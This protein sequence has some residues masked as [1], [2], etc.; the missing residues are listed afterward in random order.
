MIEFY[1][2]TTPNGFKVA[3]CLEEMNLPYNINEVDILQGV[4]KQDWFLKL[5]PNGKIPVIVDTENDDFPVFESG[6]ILL[7]L[8]EKTGEFLPKD[9]KNRSRVIQWLMFQMGGIGPM[10]GQASVFYRYAPEKIEYAINRYRKEC[11]RLFGVLDKQLE[12]NKYICGDYSI[13]DMATYPW[14]VGYEWNGV[15]I[16]P[17]EHLK[18]WLATVGDRPKVAKGMNTPPNEMHSMTVEQ[19]LELAAKIRGIVTK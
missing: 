17:F 14:V 7:Y 13:A 9:E 11:Q 2:D 5:N 18:R 3:I 15:D 8:A 6:A 19:R 10:M 1:T 16:E 12:N 4:Q